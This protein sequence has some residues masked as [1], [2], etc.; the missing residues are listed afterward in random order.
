MKLKIVK[1]SDELFNQH[2]NTQDLQECLADACGV[3][4][5]Q[6]VQVR[7]TSGGQL[8]FVESDTFAEVPEGKSLECLPDVE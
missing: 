8:V 3:A 7:P 4:D 6:V 5:L 1:V 2:P